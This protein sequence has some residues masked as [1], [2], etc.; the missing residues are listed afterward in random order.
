MECVD[1]VL[2]FSNSRDLSQQLCCGVF[3]KLFSWLFLSHWRCV[4]RKEYGIDP[5]TV[6]KWLRGSGMALTGEGEGMRVVPQ[7]T[8]NPKSN[9]RKFEKSN[10]ASP[11]KLA[12]LVARFGG[13]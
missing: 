8:L 11:E 6:A 9:S 1:V 10:R 2:G 4:M 7:S 12:A 13:V 3:W 5:L